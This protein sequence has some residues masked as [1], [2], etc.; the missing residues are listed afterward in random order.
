MKED[1]KYL[2]CCQIQENR[3]ANTPAL[4]ETVGKPPILHLA[5]SN[6]T[7]DLCSLVLMTACARSSSAGRKMM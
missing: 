2:T 6:V 5:I 7:I 1:D 4:A 3:D